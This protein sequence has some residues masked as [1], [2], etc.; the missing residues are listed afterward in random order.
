V[1]YFPHGAD[2]SG[3]IWQMAKPQMKK[4]QAAQ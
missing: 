3:I 2:D 1:Q 4:V